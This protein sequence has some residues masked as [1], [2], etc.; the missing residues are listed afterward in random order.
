MSYGP[1]REVES[2]QEE[3]AMSMERRT[4]RRWAALGPLL[5]GLILVGCKSVPEVPPGRK[6][7][8]RATI[9]PTASDR[10]EVAF[11]S[12]PHTAVSPSFAGGAPGSSALRNNA[13]PPNPFDAPPAG[14]PGS[15]ADE[16]RTGYQPQAP[17]D[18]LGMRGLR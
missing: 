18:G 12:A 17:S 7:T 9:P 15:G 2:P 11:G 13:L 16:L 3:G 14:L 10:A 5:A 8:S 4:P 6:M 1:G